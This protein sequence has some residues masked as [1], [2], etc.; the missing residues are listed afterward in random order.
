MNAAM[1]EYFALLDKAGGGTISRINS[2]LASAI[3]ACNRGDA[4]QAKTY[5]Q[6]ATALNSQLG[7]VILPQFVQWGQR[8]PGYKEA[9]PSKAQRD[10]ARGQVADIGDAADVGNYTG[11]LDAKKMTVGNWSYYQRHNLGAKASQ[12]FNGPFVIGDPARPG[13]TYTPGDLATAKPD[14]QVPGGPNLSQWG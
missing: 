2:L 5:V 8:Q 7:D 14:A 12:I 4:A 3:D 13:H 1:H 9:D 6:E 10:A 11:T